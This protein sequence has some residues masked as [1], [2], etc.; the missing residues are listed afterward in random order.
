MAKTMK[1]IVNWLK[2]WFYDKGEINNSEPEYIVGTHGTTATATWS[3][4]CSKLT[5][6]KDGT[7]IFFYLTSAGASNVTLNLTLANGTST[8]AKNVYF[9]GTTRLSTHYPINS[10]VALAY[11]T[12]K[13]NGAWYVISANDNNSWNATEYGT[14]QFTAGEALTTRTLCG[15]KNDGKYYMAK[16][17]VV[18]NTA[19]P[20][21]FTNGAISSGAVS[22][23]MYNPRYDESITNTKSIT[24][25][26]AKPVFL[27]GTKYENGEFTVSSN[28]VTQTLTAGCYYWLL[29]F[30][31]GASNFRSNVYE[32]IL[33]Y[34]GSTLKQVEE[35]KLE[36]KSDN[37]FSDEEFTVEPTSSSSQNVVLLDS[38]FSFKNNQ[39]WT[40][41]G[42]IK[43]T[44]LGVRFQIMEPGQTTKNYIAIGKNNSGNLS[45]WW[46]TGYST[47]SGKSYTAND[48]AVNTWYPFSITKKG[49]NVT[50]CFDNNSLLTHSVDLPYFDSIEELT[51]NLFKYNVNGGSVRNV[52]VSTGHPSFGAEAG[53]ICQG[54]DSRLSNTRTPTDN[55]VS[56][57]KIQNGAVT[58]A[59]LGVT[60]ITSSSDLDFNNYKTPGFYFCGLNATVNLMSNTP[61][62]NTPNNGK[63]FSLIV[64]KHAGVRQIVFPYS[65][66]DNNIYTRNFYNN[67]WSSSWTNISL[68]GH[69]HA[70]SDISGLTA[71]KNVVTG[72]DGKLTT[73]NKPTI[74]SASSTAT[75][76]KMNGTQSAGSLST[77]AKADH[78]HPSDTNKVN[79][80]QGTA[81]M[82][83]VT[84]SDK[85]VTLEAKNNHSHGSLASGGTLNSDISSVNKVAVTDSS[86]NLKTISKLPFGKLNISL[87]DL[88]ALGLL[89]NSISSHKKTDLSLDT[90]VGG[91][92]TSSSYIQFYK[93]GKLVVAYFRIISSTNLT[94]SYV[95]FTYSDTPIP[96]EYRPVQDRINLTHCH[97]DT[98]TPSILTT[99][100][101]T[102]GSVTMRINTSTRQVNTYVTMIWVTS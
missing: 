62:G 93:I 99:W 23:N 91:Y 74:P 78:I 20:L 3:G 21:I 31:Y 63:A 95:P 90:T 22:N 50:F 1:D 41:T 6:I 79:V 69:T 82:N 59:K 101:K 76:I 94:T 67:S 96:S 17:G 8:G 77:F 102:D 13:D 56:T 48:I 89:E 40:V 60:E 97:Y 9:K 4:T 88:T 14:V 24:L 81:N 92:F 29:G 55:S 66:T 61:W 35:K 38:N 36:Y 26:N 18:F 100:V 98:A 2:Q 43:V 52:R 10:I 39:N 44:G 27:E 51:I 15:A 45:V 7:V 11:T 34:D 49:Q 32:K 12:K 87:S 28:I 75:D 70:S 65:P 85:K 47:E 84:G 86:N 72:S 71:S 73:E 57:A 53:T 58:N 80:T 83:L 68:S 46:A 16:S 42:E 33:Y 5:Q 37:W 19:Y 25:T 64:L 54:N 30:A